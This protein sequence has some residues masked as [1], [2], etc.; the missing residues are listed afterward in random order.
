M[1]DKLTAN[2][3]TPQIQTSFTIRVNDDLVVPLVLTEVVEQ[4]AE[5][6]VPGTGRIPFSLQFHG[7]HRG[8][9]PQQ[10]WRLEH[11]SLGMLDIF[12][13]PLGPDSQGMRYEAVFN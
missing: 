5:L 6:A 13:V 11:E 3:F 1:L 4:R 8:H 9:L 2:D 10:I 7:N 12:L